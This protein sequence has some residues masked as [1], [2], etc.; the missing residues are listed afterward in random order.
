M[1][2]KENYL[3]SEI[4]E[5]LNSA[6]IFSCGIESQGVNQNN[7]G[8]H[9]GAF[10]E[11]ISTLK[12]DEAKSGL[13][14]A[15]ARLSQSHDDPA[16]SMHTEQHEQDRQDLL[17]LQNYYDDGEKYLVEIEP[18]L[19]TNFPKNTGRT[20]VYKKGVIIEYPETTSG[21]GGINDHLRKHVILAHEA[22]GHLLLHIPA[23]SGEESF[24]ARP[25][26]KNPDQEVQA[27]R[28]AE[29]VLAYLAV[30]YE[31]SGIPHL[32][33]SEDDL[34]NAIQIVMKGEVDSEG[35]TDAAACEYDI[36]LI[37]GANGPVDRNLFRK[38]S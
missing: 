14:R 9:L 15:L 7:N 1:V 2:Y 24:Q 27:S 29:Y 32:D 8:P 34:F 22:V 16:S 17:D 11:I 23:W 36:R 4:Y 30:K 35:V 28:A 12:T 5:Y 26:M 33:V 6:R 10:L 20:L 13:P 31:G 38:A 37:E 25:P 19:D 18:T 3:D 21:N